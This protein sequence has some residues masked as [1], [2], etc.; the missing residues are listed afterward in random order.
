MKL[1]LRL[2]YYSI[3]LAIIAIL[4]A[5]YY[6]VFA[7][8]L[9][10]SDVPQLTARNVIQNIS[11]DIILLPPTNAPISPNTDPNHP[12]FIALLN[13]LNAARSVINAPT[14][15]LQAQLNAAAAV[16]AQYN[17]DIERLSHEGI[18]GEFAPERVDAQAYLWASVG[19]NILSRWDVD[20][21]GVFLQW[22]ASHDHNVNMMNPKFTEIGL[23]YV[24]TEIGEVY[25]AMVLATPR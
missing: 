21:H 4:I 10:K 15:G 22:Q 9:F 20:G 2:I 11:P 12:S 25:Y 17:A 5:A 3:I 8:D 19:E 13:D 7:S 18:N 14:L 6:F 23:A 16:Q 24:V 1:L